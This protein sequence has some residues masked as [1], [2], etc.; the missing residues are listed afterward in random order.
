MRDHHRLSLAERTDFS[1]GRRL[2][3]WQDHNGISSAFIPI[4]VYITTMSSPHVDS[5]IRRLA[6]LLE[7]VLRYRGGAENTGLRVGARA[8]ERKLGW[9]AGTLSRVLKGKIEFRVRHVLDVLEV[10]RIPPQDFFELAY[11]QPNS[12]TAQELMRFLEARKLRGGFDVEPL[13]EKEATVSD[14][15]LDLRILEALRRISLKAEP[16]SA[17]PEK[18]RP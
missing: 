3:L 17:E 9:S 15:E 18:S 14:A 13:V 12:T 11:G 2:Y 16:P 7:A 1:V 4:L 8:I 6:D 10:L 5:E